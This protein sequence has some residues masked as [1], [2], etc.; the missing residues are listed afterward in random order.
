MS[1][2]ESPTNARR[3]VEVRAMAHRD[4]KDLAP[5]KTFEDETDQAD[6]DF[7]YD[8]SAFRP[9]MIRL[10]LQDQATYRRVAAQRLEGWHAF[11]D[12]RPINP[13]DRD[14]PEWAAWMSGWHD[15]HQ[16]NS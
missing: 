1:R 13:Y 8:Q 3:E 2:Y 7:M 12:S 6:Y 4:A 11:H 16:E 14:T 5:R 10:S 9:L 15:A